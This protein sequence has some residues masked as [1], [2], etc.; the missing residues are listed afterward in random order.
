MTLFT[1][2]LSVCAGALLATGILFTGFCSADEEHIAVVERPSTKVA[3]VNY[4]ASRAPLKPLQFIKL[5]VGS[6]QPEGWL[7]KYL[8]LQRDGLTGH[9]GE[10]SA[11]LEKNDNAWLTAGGQHGW[12]EVPYWLKGYG[13]LAYILN[14]PKMIAETKVWLE[15]VFKSVQPDGYFGPVNEQDGRREL[16]A[17]MIMLWCMQSYY[18]YSG[19]QRVIDLMTNYFKWQLTVDDSKFLR[20]YWE[21]SRGGDNLWSV[22]WL[23][24]IT[25]DSFLLELA[26]KIHRCTADWTMDSR[27]PNWHNVN[28]AQCFREP[29]TYYMLSGD[30]AHLAASYNVHALIRRCFGQVP[31]GMFGADENARMGCIDPRQGTETCGFVE[32]MASD[33][34]M[35]RITG[36][37]MWA[38]QCE[39]VA[40]NSYPAAVM[41]DFRALR[42]ITSPNQVLSDAQNHNPGIDNGGPFLAMNPFSSRCCQHNHA[43]GWPYYTEHLVMA[44]PDNGLVA[45]LYGACQVKAKV[46]NGKEIV[47]K[48]TTHYPFEETIAFTVDTK[49]NVN[50]PFY[51]RIPSWT[52]KVQVK[53]N[54]ERMKV[55]PVAGE[56]FRIERTWKNGDRVE[57]VLPMHLTMRTWQVNKNSV[58]VNYGPLTLS[59][60][61]GEEFIRR[62]SRETAIGDSKWQKGADA[63]NWPSYEIHPTTAWN[64]ALVLGEKDPLEG[65]EV[66]KKSWPSDNFPFTPG[67]V[68]LEVK[69][70]GRRIPSWKIDKYGLCA[71]LPETD[72]P[73]SP[74]IENITL[75][76]MGAARLRI[77][78]FPAV[79]E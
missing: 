72:A 51:L 5:P 40:F 65:F 49:E 75:I 32:E 8:E 36:D 52:R 58:S 23:Y 66:V 30:S 12:E 50:F 69:A 11:W 79:S 2:S 16:W 54:G 71:V 34:L 62:D 46:G 22:Y 13:N 29:A 6:I 78:A 67:N 15:G 44:T 37:P 73:K 18:E 21:N 45:A 38:E 61:I 33:E 20:D 10:I 43:Q 76:P 48:E 68:P 64:Y 4:T 7:R 60:K 55:S 28:V 56:Y 1:K 77:S 53:V 39:N 27:L 74:Q 25:G 47:L 42:Y 24:N 19:D 63:E 3:N 35:M 70:Q 14:D 59:L 9:L 26:E 57:L 41:P 17:N 31:G